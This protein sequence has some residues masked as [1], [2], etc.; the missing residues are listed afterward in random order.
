MLGC[1]NSDEDGDFRSDPKSNL[2]IASGC[3]EGHLQ[4]KDGSE[5]FGHHYF[6]IDKGKFKHLRS[7]RVKR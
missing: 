6:L 4:D 7:V 5:Q 2:V 3:L 1:G